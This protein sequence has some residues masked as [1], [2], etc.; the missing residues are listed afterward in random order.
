LKNKFEIENFSGEKPL[1]IEQD[2]HAVVLLSNIAS[3]I[4]N[5]A[6]EKINVSRHAKYKYK[7]NKNILIGKLKNT[8]IELL[9]QDNSD[10]LVKMYEH[11][12]YEVKRN[13]IPVIEGR[14]FKR[15]MGLKSNKYPQTRRRAL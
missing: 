8:L 9:L 6:E 14:H 5:E 11:L 2:F 4:A 15:K 1:I 10:T 7:I 13:I 12:I 3:I